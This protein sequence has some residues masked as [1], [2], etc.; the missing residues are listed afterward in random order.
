MADEKQGAQ[1]SLWE[2]ALA[3][4]AEWAKHQPSLSAQLQAMMREAAKD[5]H[6]KMDQAFFG[7]TPGMG[8]PGTPLVPTQAMITKDLG[9]VQGYQSMLEDAAARPGQEREPS[10]ER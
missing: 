3:K 4:R 6:A 7:Q 1:P 5:V 9:T 8:E 2:Q 10:R